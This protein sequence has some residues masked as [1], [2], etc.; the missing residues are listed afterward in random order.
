MPF[1]FIDWQPPDTKS[2]TDAVHLAVV[3]LEHRQ[4]GQPLAIKVAL[5]VA[6]MQATLFFSCKLFY[7]QGSMPVFSFCMAHLLLSLAAAGRTPP[8]A[9]PTRRTHM[10]EAE[11]TRKGEGCVKTG[12]LRNLSIQRGGT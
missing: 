5:L 9:R 6:V 10:P 8:V 7:H 12:T 4:Y 1:F 3:T 2:A 11:L